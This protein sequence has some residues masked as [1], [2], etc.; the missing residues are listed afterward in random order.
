MT[1]RPFAILL[2]CLVLA[3]ATANP[4]PS[5]DPS[6]AQ[7]GSLDATLAA[8][9]GGDTGIIARTFARPREFEERRHELDRWL[10]SWDRGKALVLLEMARVASSVAPRYT[11]VMA[12]VGRTYIDRSSAGETAAF[13]QTWHEAAAGL[14]QLASDP[15]QVEAYVSDVIGKTTPDPSNRLAGRLLLA[16]AVAQERRCWDGR[17]ALEQTSPEVEALAKAAGMVVPDDR[18]GLAKAGRAGKVSSHLTCLGEA[19]TR[20]EVAGRDET[21]VE[22]SVRT[23]W[24]LFQSGRF[25]EALDR[26]DVVAPTDDRDVAFW[27][28]LFRGRALDALGRTSDAAAAY[29]SALAL[30]PTAQSAGIGLVLALTRLDQPAEADVRA[31][32]LRTAGADGADPWSHY[33]SGDNRLVDGWLTH[34][35]AVLR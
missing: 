22:A 31:R 16:R 26:L 14:L 13:V 12:N 11:L 5:A 33:M 29:R 9:I 8:Y 19:L 6:P 2:P 7:G 27:L 18:D 20:L 28:A 24:I 30:V 15:W 23:G 35:R 32:A 10:K 21:R 17:P 3:A 25:R 4:V 34:M 1:I